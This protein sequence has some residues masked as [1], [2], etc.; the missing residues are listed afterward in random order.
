MKRLG[1]IAGV[2]LVFILAALA[3]VKIYDKGKDQ[4]RKWTGS[5]R[6]DIKA[7]PADRIWT[8]YTEE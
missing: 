4:K 2:L 3:L 8:D 7:A 6:F 1:S 5:Y